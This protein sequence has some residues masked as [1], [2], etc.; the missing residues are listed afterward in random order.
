MSAVKGWIKTRIRDIFE[1]SI[2]G[3]WGTEGT[4]ENGVPVLRS[5]NFRNNGSID[6]SDITYRKVEKQSLTK[7][8]VGQGSILIEKSGGSPTQPAGR[9]VYCDRD[10][11]GTA[12]NFIEVIKVKNNFSPRYVAFLLYYLYQS[13]LVLKYQQQTTG[14]I[15]FKL[16][17]YGEEIVS[18][19][20]SIDEQTKIAEILSC[21]DTAIEQT[22]AIIAKQQRIKTGLMQ[23]LLS[24]GI[25]EHG[26]IRTEHTHAFKDSPLGRIPEEWEVKQLGQIFQLKSGITPL[27]SNTKYF[28]FNGYNW[29]KTLDL[30]ESYLFTTEEKISDFALKNT[31]I[32][33][34]PKNSLLVAMYGGWEQ[35]GRTAILGYKA[36]TNQAITCLY[37]AKI[38]VEPEFAQIA[39]QYFRYTWRKFA[40]STRKDPNITKTD[41]ENFLIPFPCDIREQK[42]ISK[43]IFN[44]KQDIDILNNQ[45]VKL[46]QT[47]TA[48]MQDLLSGKVRVN[49]LLNSE[50]FT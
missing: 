36:A 42:E 8:Y 32:S 4:P 16:N 12:S 13:G 9:V 23:D 28:D 37:N 27:R 15:N 1:S 43:I 35:I 11:K 18:F 26:N 46:R 31:S 10:L 38:D 33:L 19:P 45:L 17:E 2:A 5:T 25:D 50:K 40:V 49:Q 39:L 30:N 7:R 14:I 21:I 22:E 29:V 6:Y 47:K 34:M 20:E 48:L 41:I 44:V 24:K 3:D